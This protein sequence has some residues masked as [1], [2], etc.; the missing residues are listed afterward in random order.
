[1]G[2]CGDSEYSFAHGEFQMSVSRS[3]GRIESEERLSESRVRRVMGAGQH[4][5]LTKI[6]KREPE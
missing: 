6:I 1:M 2:G 4:L 5:D 3:S